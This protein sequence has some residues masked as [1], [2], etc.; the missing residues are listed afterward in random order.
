MHGI[1][2]FSTTQ[3]QSHLVTELAVIPGNAGDG[4]YLMAACRAP[5]VHYF[6]LLAYQSTAAVI[7]MCT[8]QFYSPHA[9]LDS[10]VGPGLVDQV[11][12]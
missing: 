2:S 6:E 5:P 3:V 11:Q 12:A 9:E 4:L 1:S 10:L 7:R 8:D